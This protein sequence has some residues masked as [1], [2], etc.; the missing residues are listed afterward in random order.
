MFKQRLSLF[1]VRLLAGGGFVLLTG[2]T[3]RTGS[4]DSSSIEEILFTSRKEGI[5]IRNDGT[6]LADPKVELIDL[7]ELVDKEQRENGRYEAIAL[8][9]EGD[10]LVLDTRTGLTRVYQ[11]D[12]S[13]LSVYNARVP[14]HYIRSTLRGHTEPAD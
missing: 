6:I 2:L 8:G 12:I 3:T 11:P 5:T 10:F 4:D 1:L 13:G 7:P 14:N 9:T